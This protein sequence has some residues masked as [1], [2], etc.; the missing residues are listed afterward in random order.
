MP[1]KLETGIKGTRTP[2]ELAEVLSQFA[3]TLANGSDVLY[4]S[5]RWVESRVY[6]AILGSGTTEREAN[7]RA[8]EV[9]RWMANAAEELRDGMLRLQLISEVLR[10]PQVAK[11]RWLSEDLS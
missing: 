4:D 6:R 11:Q 5:K 7:Q 2:G 3:T 10:D 1:D 8:A 9:N